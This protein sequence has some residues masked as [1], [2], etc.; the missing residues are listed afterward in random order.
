MA[1]P[2]HRP[3][4]PEPVPLESR[5]KHT[6]RMWGLRER[7]G[8]AE[9]DV[10]LHPEVSQGSKDAIVPMADAGILPVDS[11]GENSRVGAGD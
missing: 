3:T 4:P 1:I 10:G 5:G 6:N 9:M 2:F 8:R 11:I 7:L